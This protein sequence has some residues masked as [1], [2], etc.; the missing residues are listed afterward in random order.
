VIEKLSDHYKVGDTVRCMLGGG[1]PYYQAMGQ[2]ILLQ[3]NGNVTVRFDKD[4]Y[5]ATFASTTS[6]DL[7]FRPVKLQGSHGCVPFKCCSGECQPV[8]FEKKVRSDGFK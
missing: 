2:V 8:H 5:E 6:L 4:G 7:E 1:Y 3:K